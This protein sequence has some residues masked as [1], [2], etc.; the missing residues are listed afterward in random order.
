MKP[1]R[2]ILIFGQKYV[3]KA[4]SK[5]PTRHLDGECCKETHTITYDPTLK[6]DKLAETILHEMFHA[7]FEEVSLAQ[8]ISPELEEICVDTMAKAVARNFTLT[9]KK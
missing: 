3:L 4:D 1:P 5:L 9:S 6:G 8:A 2:S 7:V